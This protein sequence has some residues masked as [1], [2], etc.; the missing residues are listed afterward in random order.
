MHPALSVIVFTVLSGAGFGLVMLAALTAL[1]PSLL[2]I[3]GGERLAAGVL[4]TVLATAGLM[5]STLHLANPKNAWRAFFRFRTSWLSRE[6]VFSVLFYPCVAVWLGGA[7]WFGE[8]TAL[9]WLAAALAL[10][11]AFATVFATGM[12]YASLRAIPNWH[13]PLV[14]TNYLL[15]AFASGSLLLLALQAVMRGEAPSQSMITLTLVLL[16]AAALGKT[17]YFYWIGSP[18]GPSIN[19]ATGMTQGQVRLLHTGQSSENTFLDKEFRFQVAAQRLRWLRLA[20]AALG[21]ALPLVLVATLLGGGEVV[22]VLL[23]VP[24]ALVGLAIERW[25]FFAEARHVV[26]LFYGEQR[27]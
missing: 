5:A 19:T 18:Q 1:L 3:T 16:A 27:V 12:I 14:P 25:L 23:A 13:S 9:I 4:G 21:F 26:N 6:A 10:V 11:L 17:V 7:W 15:L 20:A 22:P 2:P 24:V 8:A